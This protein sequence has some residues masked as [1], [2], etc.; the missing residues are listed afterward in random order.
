VSASDS[1]A[2][3]IV[4]PTS[5]GEFLG[6]PRG[7]ATLFFTEMWERFSYY[8]MRALLILFMTAAA[9]HGGLG[10]D[11]EH[12][13]AVYGLYTAGTYLCS[14]PGGW[15]AD[16]LL[17]QRASVLWG[18][19]LISLGNL[20]LA[21]PARVE[22]FYIGLTVVALGT[23]MLKP[24][25]S[26]LVGELY[27]GD[28]GSRRDSAFSIYYLGINLGAFIAPLVAGTIGEERGYRWGFLAA[29]IAM[30]LGVVQYRMTGHWLGDAGLRPQAS[31]RERR[32]SRRLLLAGI[33]LLA[34]LVIAAAS[35]SVH[36]D[37]FGLASAAGVLMV[38]LAVVFFG[39]VLGFAGLSGLEK[40]R[41]VVIAIFVASSALFWAG[42]E[43]AGS[44]LNLFARDDTDRSFL[45]SWFASGQHP[46]T[47]YQSF[48]A[49]FI[50]LLAPVF[51]W[52]W[53]ALGRRKRD[54]SA[55][56]KFGWALLQLG[57]S[58]LVM[59]AAARLVF[60]SGHRVLP[61]WLITTYLLQT[62]GELCLSPIGLSNVTKLAPVRFAGQMMGTW[63]LGTAIGDLA[64]GVL[65]GEAAAGS[66]AQMSVQFLHMGLLGLA[67]GIVMLLV[68]R[69][70]RAWM[71]GVS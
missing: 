38:A 65:G 43:Q 3:T 34:A 62:T 58:F 47:W 32:R 33:V 11:D 28:S 71:G 70:L 57:L 2:T 40:K 9:A 27:R 44:S 1:T 45:G 49:I 23:G 37:V 42:Y 53:L 13:G 60:T 31:E 17:G 66:M 59:M 46:A 54:P 61:G 41:V 14:L 51:A 69:P 35:G 20:L 25:T 19:A 68:A 10:L 64:A 12:A 8:G 18:G 52:I 21:L 22:L 56:A 55:P 24:N 16:R 26:C 30:A 50:L 29:G 48:Q 67:A 15:L 5:A 7:L 4:R 39:A 36:F 6:H 63:F